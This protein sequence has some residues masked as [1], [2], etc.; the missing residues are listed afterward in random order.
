MDQLW[1][2][3][4]IYNLAEPIQISTFFSLLSKPV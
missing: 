1:G 4:L 2:I 3:A